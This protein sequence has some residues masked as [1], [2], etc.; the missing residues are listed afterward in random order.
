[1]HHHYA[2]QEQGYRGSNR[3]SEDVGCWH[4]TKLAVCAKCLLVPMRIHNSVHKHYPWS[5][6]LFWLLIDA[7]SSKLILLC[8]SLLIS[9]VWSKQLQPIK[10]KLCIE[11][12]TA[13]IFDMSLAEVNWKLVR[14]KAKTLKGT[15]LVSFK[16][17]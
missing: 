15:F 11:Y 7:K 10:S 6:I 16:I 4:C 8:V 3:T 1:M 9:N 2:R 13:W 17:Y 12:S 14:A 5:L